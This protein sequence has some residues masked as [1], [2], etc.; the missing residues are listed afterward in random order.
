MKKKIF[1]DQKMLICDCCSD[2]KP[3]INFKILGCFHI[4]CIACCIK[5]IKLQKGIME[6]EIEVDVEDFICFV[7]SCNYPIDK[8]IINDVVPQTML[9]KNNSNM[10]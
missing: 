7:K 5:G 4:I 1:Y 9:I 8:E 2:E 3:E 6:K 10:S